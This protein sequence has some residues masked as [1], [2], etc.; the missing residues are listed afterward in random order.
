MHIHIH[1]KH[2]IRTTHLDMADNCSFL[3]KIVEEEAVFPLVCFIFLCGAGSVYV[4]FC[5]FVCLPWHSSHLA[6]AVCSSCAK[7]SVRNVAA[8]ASPERPDQTRGTF[9]LSCAE[10]VGERASVGKASQWCGCTCAMLPQGESHNQNKCVDGLM[11][12]IKFV[13]PT[14]SKVSILASL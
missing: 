14:L 12:G 10:F 6:V 9:N 4:I 2:L 3:C 13:T 1:F 5:L 7:G 8:P 11:I